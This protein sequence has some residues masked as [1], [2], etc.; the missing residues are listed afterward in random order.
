MKKNIIFI[1]ILFAWTIFAAQRFV[2]EEE[3]NSLICRAD[4]STYTINIKIHAP[5]MIIDTITEKYKEL[6]GEGEEQD[7]V[8]SYFGS[9]VDALN[10]YLYRFRVQLHLFLN[11]YTIEKTMGGISVTPYCESDAPIQK[12]TS[13]ALTF[14][15]SS[16]PTSVGIHY[17]LWGCLSLDNSKPVTFVH[18]NQ[19]CGRCIGSGWIGTQATREVMMLAILDA[20]TGPKNNDIGKKMTDHEVATGLCKYAAECVGMT[21]SEIGQIVEGRVPV[22]YTDTYADRAHYQTGYDNSDMKKFLTETH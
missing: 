21:K 14:L 4:N 15:T 13:D 1:F 18:V 19:L 9:I 7:A 3:D 22:R 20:L 16:Y 8:E 2:E 17:F 12:K 11:E 10:E 6:G 5:Q